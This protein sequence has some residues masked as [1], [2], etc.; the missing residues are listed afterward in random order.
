M[1]T[2]NSHLA[3]VVRVWGEEETFVVW[4]DLLCGENAFQQGSYTV[5]SACRYSCEFPCLI[6]TVQPQRAKPGQPS[7]VNNHGS[8]QMR[9]PFAASVGCAIHC[10][11]TAAM[12]YITGGEMRRY[13][14]LF[15]QTCGLNFP[16]TVR[17]RPGLIVQRMRTVTR[18][19]RYRK[20]LLCILCSSIMF[21][22]K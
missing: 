17:Q 12:W 14:C 2:T 22:F 3:V 13:F 1:N 4:R 19:N 8:G 10:N 20:R 9:T 16:R 11:T 6:A 21:C 5:N 7:E 18:R 15:V